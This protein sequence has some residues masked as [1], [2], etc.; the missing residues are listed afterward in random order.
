M[1]DTRRLAVTDDEAAA[2]AV[3]AYGSWR[4]PLP[5]VHETDAACLTSAIQRGRRSLEIRDLAGPGGTV[6]GDAAEVLKRLGTGLCAAFMLIDEDS[7][8]MPAGPT[9]YLYGRVPDD[10]EMSHVV[11]GAG[12]HYFRVEPPPNQW[13]ALTELAEA[14]FQDGFSVAREGVQQP[15]AALLSVIREAGIRSVRVAHRGASAVQQP[16]PMTFASVAEA[17]SWLQA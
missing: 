16:D 2:I 6:I 17:V 9:V 15:A 10:V 7:N 3:Q 14:V 13:L 5:T 12:V 11:A 4:A 8:W 1:A